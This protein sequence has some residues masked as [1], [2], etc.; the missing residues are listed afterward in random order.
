MIFP[1]NFE[2]KIGFDGIRTILKKNC[3]CGLGKQFVDEIKFSSNIDIIKKRL[4][5]ADEFRKILIFE[6]SFPSYNYI[7]VTPELQRISLEGTF[8][9][10]EMLFDLKCSYSTIGDCI[11][12]VKKLNKE[13]YP[14]IVEITAQINFLTDIIKQI[15]LIIDERGVIRDNAS[16][17]LK[18]IRK[19][20]ISKQISID[21]KIKTILLNLK[22]ESIIPDDTEI[23]IRNGR[24]VLPV[25]ASNKR[26]LKGFVHDESATGQTVFIEPT[27]ILELNNDLRDLE[28]EEKREIVNILTLFTSE[29]RPFI[30]EMVSSYK[31]LGF[32]D[33]LRA[34][35]TL[36][37]E[38]GAF[39]PLIFDKPI[40]NWY[41]AYN[42]ILYLLFKKTGKN[43]VPF[44]IFI[45]EEKKI[46][47][48][49]GPNAGGKSVVLKSVGLIQ[50]MLQCGLLSTVKE[51]SEAG[52][53]KDIFIEIGDEQ[54]I[55]N[56]LSTYSSHL[57]NMK[58]LVE[59]AD[60]GSLFLIDEMG[61]G[62]E[63]QLGG[64]IAESIIEKL[65]L[66]NVTGIITTH[67]TNIKL[68]A[69]K[70]NSIGNA[71]MLY[72]LKN[73]KPLFKLK[74]GNPGSS[75]AFEI[76]GNIGFPGDILKMAAD[77]IGKNHLDFDRQ[78]QQMETD[79]LE[80]KKKQDEIK[81]ADDFLAEMI[82]KYQNKI[83]ELEARK[84]EIIKKAKIEAQN[85]I[86]EA[87]RLIE[88]TIKSIKESTADK[89]ITK[90]A[91]EK[92]TS[93]EKKKINSTADN[94]INSPS[95]SNIKKEKNEYKIIKSISFNIGDKVKLKDQEIF[96]EITEI[97]NTIATV[98]TEYLTLKIPFVNLIKINDIP[99]KKKKSDKYGKIINE[100][101]EK[102]INF[103][104]RID[105]RGCRAD[106]IIPIIQKYIDDALLVGFYEISILH[107]KGNGV[108]RK[109]IR[110]YLRVMHDVESFK[111]EILENG[112]DGITLVKLRNK[113]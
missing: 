60:S 51:Y 109:I 4:D 34:K 46:L 12:Y 61:A 5:Q 80:I 33:F 89:E 110:E 14:N 62:T 107:G 83:N 36:S 54:S 93:F 81:V 55:E 112:G 26:K 68:M 70:N 11:K 40:I 56:N 32:F 66:K 28:N 23:T 103:S 10:T 53:F 48:I 74:Q 41:T 44:D 84:T 98:A 6:E 58:L 25:P 52:I 102:A 111:D 22:K 19:E 67:Y 99:L 42:P 113:L 105:V 65:I 16:E 57:L 50:Y 45:G 87:N 20:Y 88:S 69:A 7:D 72:D 21:R 108:L 31:V 35:A 106:E 1:D 75:F 73:L 64:A 17:R 3:L 63:P 13:K 91:R 49:S 78:L 30:P 59:K 2:S 101:N 100:I 90:Q 29:L 85:L 82:D 92:I 37:I 9:S 39:K 77:K 38:L 95:K 96:G 71:A 104:T 18:S 8:I 86:S 24:M 97:N 76:A 47:V 43:V 94:T 79:K 15:E 27:E